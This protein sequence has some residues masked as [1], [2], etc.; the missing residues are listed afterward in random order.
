MS[1]Y[2]FWLCYTKRFGWS[3]LAAELTFVSGPPLARLVFVG[4][5]LT[6]F[7]I[8]STGYPP[9]PPT[10]STSDEPAGRVFRWALDDPETALIPSVVRRT[11]CLWSFGLAP[12]LPVLPVSTGHLVAKGEAWAVTWRTSTG[13]NT[14]PPQTNKNQT[15][16]K[17]SESEIG[18]VY[19][20]TREKLRP[21]DLIKYKGAEAGVETE[22]LATR[23]LHQYV[24]SNMYTPHTH[25]SACVSVRGEVHVEVVVVRPNK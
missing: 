1:Q 18:F 20:R 9:C 12:Y 11:I 6:D 5:R 2:F 8:G 14:K 22:I 10:S 24:S 17:T 3:R 13:T 21:L 16:S 7:L 25:T 23:R 4:R 15:K 19:E